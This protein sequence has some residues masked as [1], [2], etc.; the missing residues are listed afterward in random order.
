M[1]FLTCVSR[2]ICCFIIALMAV[3][4]Q[5]LGLPVI[6]ITRHEVMTRL[7]SMY[8]ENVISV[9]DNRAD[10]LSRSRAWNM[11]PCIVTSVLRHLLHWSSQIIWG[12]RLFRS[13]PRY[14]A[15]FNDWGLHQ[16]RKHLSFQCSQA[17]RHSGRQGHDSVK[18]HS[19]LA[20]QRQ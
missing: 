4:P 12:Y 5:H 13:T 20:T 11:I 7:E 19:D 2:N 3:R 17:K 14:L 18:L 8:T 15:D 9:L 16:A 10:I 1:Q 6:K